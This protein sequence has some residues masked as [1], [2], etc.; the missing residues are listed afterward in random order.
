MIKRISVTYD[1]RIVPGVDRSVLDRVMEFHASHCPVARS[2]GGCID[3]S[4]NLNVIEESN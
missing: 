3:I 1:L 2:I 4:T